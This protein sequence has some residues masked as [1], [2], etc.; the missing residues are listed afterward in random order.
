[1]NIIGIVLILFFSIDLFGGQLIAV[2][3]LKMFFR[4]WIPARLLQ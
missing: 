3:F 4:V 1:M 2:I